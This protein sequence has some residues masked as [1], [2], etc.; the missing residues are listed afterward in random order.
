[1][2][3]LLGAPLIPCLFLVLGANLAEGPGAAQVITVIDVAGQAVIPGMDNCDIAAWPGALAS[4]DSRRLP[5][6]VNA[7]G[8]GAYAQCANRLH[9]AATSLHPL[10][11]PTPSQVPSRTAR[12]RLVAKVLVH[13][14]L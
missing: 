4:A 8:I 14:L 1:V 6:L 3:T 13:P 9:A 12:G 7:V 11:T 10:F 5:A 2:T